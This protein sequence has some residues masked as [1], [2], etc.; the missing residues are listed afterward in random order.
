M[1]YY[2]DFNCLKGLKIGKKGKDSQHASGCS[3]EINSLEALLIATGFWN[4][5]E[6]FFLWEAIV[7]R[8]VFFRNSVHKT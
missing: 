5:G 1:S 4:V 8:K 2:L 3:I 6:N 7:R